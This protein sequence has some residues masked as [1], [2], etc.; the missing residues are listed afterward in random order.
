V[1]ATGLGALDPHGTRT[2]SLP[3]TIRL[4][5]AVEAGSAILRGGTVPIA[6][7]GVLQSGP[8]PAPFSLRTTAQ[9]R[10]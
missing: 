7:D 2:V 8:A 6:L 10:R 4:A 3:L 1:S 5:G 9:F